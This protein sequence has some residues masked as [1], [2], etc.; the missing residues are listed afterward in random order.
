[1][2]ALSV[3]LSEDEVKCELVKMMSVFDRVCRAHGIRYSLDSGTLLGA[4]RHRGF[5][6][7]DDDIDLIIPR[8]DYDR[9]LSHPEWFDAPFSIVA[10]GD[11]GSV[12]PFAKMV[13]RVWRAQEPSLEG[14][15]DE[16]LW[17]DLF[18]A[19]A[20]PDD[21]EEAERLCRRQVRLVK[22]YGQSLVN[23]KGARNA[24][25]RVVKMALQP[26][27]RA[28]VSPKQLHDA[29]IDGALQTPYGSTKNVANL[30][31]P[32]VIKKRWVPMSDFDNLIEVSFE[33]LRLL[34]IPSWDRYLSALYGDYMALPPESARIT[35]SAHVWPSE[36]CCENNSGDAAVAARGKEI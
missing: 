7:W 8:P 10:P 25:K 21:P 13:N 9:L 18:P 33:D 14:I 16:Y 30:T 4:I 15:V 2:N 35:H 26:L 27:L 32:L 19:D 34:A 22:L 29:L 36:V 11:N 31:W 24:T 28:I 3:Q 23:P 6:P 1:M 12:H 17:I 20:V 5:I